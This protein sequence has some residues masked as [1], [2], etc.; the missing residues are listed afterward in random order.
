MWPNT[1]TVLTKVAEK[2]SSCLGRR[3]SHVRVREEER[4]KQ[5]LAS[6]LP[7]FLAKFLTF[8]EVLTAK[9][10][11]EGLNDVVERV[12]GRPPQTFD[13]FVQEHKVAWLI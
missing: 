1:L 9:G 2:L 8:L 4:V 7:E 11:G 6:G 12:T 10:G 5:Y 3:V 13:A